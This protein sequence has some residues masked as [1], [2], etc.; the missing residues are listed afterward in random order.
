[1]AVS[2]NQIAQLEQRARELQGQ[3]AGIDRQIA[4][5]TQK[6]AQEFDQK[7]RELKNDTQL[8]IQEREKAIHEIYEEQL[9][10]TVS[11]QE[12]QLRSHYEK[13]KREY[14][15]V[16]ADVAKAKAELIRQT[17]EIKLEQKAFEEAY[18]ARREAE[19][20]MAQQIYENVIAEYNEIVAEV[21]MEW[22]APGHLGLYSDRINDINDRIRNTWY[23]IASA[24]G[25]NVSL[26]MRL[27]KLEVNDKLRRWQ[28]L[29]L[30]ICGMIERLRELLYNEARIIPKE[31]T[32]TAE[33][34]SI[35]ERQIPDEL[36]NIWF[37]DYNELCN[38]YMTLYKKMDVFSV[39]GEFIKIEEIIPFMQ[40]NHEKYASCF[41]E[42]DLYSI[43]RECSVLLDKVTAALSK[44]HLMINS[45]EERIS[46]I[47]DKSQFGISVLLE[48]CGYN[49]ASIDLVD[50]TTLDTPVIIAL[51]DNLNTMDFEVVVS[52]IFRIGDGAWINFVDWFYPDV[53]GYDTVT[54]L[55]HIMANAFVT[56]KISV[57]RHRKNPN[58]T[59][60]SRIEDVYNEKMLLIN[61]RIN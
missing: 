3:M 24:A 22:F 44:L 31:T 55:T 52:P 51:N 60:L 10:S 9:R 20:Q 43:K 38:A 16:C 57:S 4:H 21:P 25:E 46:M 49:I 27:D 7:I 33:V 1:M 41:R 32:K 12:E 28:N 13:T 47:F 45:Y 14:E 53:A 11:A 56:K 35:S 59:V 42:I 48:E 50:D 36:L 37:A 5:E 26:N 15:K 40:K 23:E 17:E 30:V 58:E 18:Y 54:E 39:N 29:Y 2:N 34:F 61:G 19:K 6:V 8:K